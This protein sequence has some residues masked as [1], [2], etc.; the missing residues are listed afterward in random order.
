MGAWIGSPMSRFGLATGYIYRPS[1][2]PSTIFNV[3]DYDAVGD[4]ITDDSAAI[5]TANDLADVGDTVYFPPGIYKHANGLVFRDGVSY[6][7]A[8]IYQQQ[9]PNGGT[10]LKCSVTWGSHVTVKDMLIGSNDAG[11]TTKFTPVKRGDSAAGSDTNANGSHSVLFNFVRFKGGSDSGAHLIELA[12]NCSSN[13]SGGWAGSIRTIDMYDTEW[14][15]C[16]FERPQDGTTEVA[17]L[18]IAGCGSILSIWHDCRSGGAQIHDLTFRRCH[19]GVKNSR[20]GLSGN[21]RYGIGNT[22]LFQPGPPEHSIGGPRPSDETMVLPANADAVYGWGPDW[23]SDIVDHGMYGIT[24]EDCVVEWANWVGFNPCDYARSY[25]I[26]RWNDLNRPGSE[27]TAMSGVSSAAAGWGNPPGSHW[28]DIPAEMWIRNVTTTRC[29]FKTT[30]RYELGYDS[31]NLA[32]VGVVPKEYGEDA[33]DTG[34]FT[35]DDRP[36]TAIFTSDWTSAYT[37]SP[38]DPA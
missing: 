1:P 25:S 7:G 4:G 13:S 16:E 30:T 3:M 20:A 21:A 31:V 15:D 37:V 14:R 17:G 33:S 28:V 8:G 35:N 2:E 29:Y 5:N 36:H 38:F 32:S 22:L 11:A 6:L 12:G 10:W 19:F 24:F 27:T 18:P 23:D 26:W 34:T 9:S